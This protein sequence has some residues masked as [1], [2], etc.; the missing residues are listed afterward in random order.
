MPDP[1]PS[2]GEVGAGY[3][4]EVWTAGSG[5][6]QVTDSYVIE[7]YCS[8]QE[9][10]RNLTDLVEAQGWLTTGSTG[11]VV[12][13]PAARMVADIEGRLSSL[14]DRLGLNPEARLRLGITAVEHQSRLD[15][16][17]S[18]GGGDT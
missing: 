17:L 7:R 12:V 16:F 6:Y 3:W 4:I 1:P 9:R 14:E 2:L 5:V 8:L 18:D 13:H 11:Q 15:A 10:R